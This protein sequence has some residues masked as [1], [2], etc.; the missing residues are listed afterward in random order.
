MCLSSL[1]TFSRCSKGGPRQV[2]AGFREP[3]DEGGPKLAFREPLPAMVSPDEARSTA[4]QQEEVDGQEPCGLRCRHWCCCCRVCVSVEVPSGLRPRADRGLALGREKRTRV[5]KVCLLW[6]ES[7]EWAEHWL[8]ALWP[9]CQCLGDSEQGSSLS[10]KWGKECCPPPRL[11]QGLPD[12]L[13]AS[14]P[15]LGL[16]LGLGRVWG[17]CW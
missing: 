3:L 12:S 2:G 15:T 13:S 11:F 4:S 14:G 10:R 5:T 16:G 7:P 17:C 1:R 8:G 9:A 6:L